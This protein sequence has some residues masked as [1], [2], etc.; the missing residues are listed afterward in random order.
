MVKNFEYKAKD[1]Y[2]ASLQGMMQAESEVAVAVALRSKGYFITQIKEKQINFLEMELSLFEKRITTAD[3]AIF[4]RQFAVMIEAGMP[5][6]SVLHVLIEQTE[7]KKLR[8]ATQVVLRDV[9]E[10]ETLARAMSYHQKIFPT[11]MVSMVEAG[12]LGGVLDEVMERVATHLEKEHKLREK[13]KGAMTYPKMVLAVAFVIVMVIVT[14]IFPTFTQLFQNANIELPVITKL[15]I[16][17][18]NVIRNH[19]IIIGICV[20]LLVLVVKRILILPTVRPVIDGAKLKLP[21][22]GDLIKKI[23]IA[24]FCRTLSTLVKGGVGLL[25]ALE[26]VKRVTDNHVI[27]NIVSR[28]ETSIKE[29]EGL[30]AQLATSQVFPAM[31]VRMT[32]IGEET[33][34]LDRMLEKVADFFESE[35]EDKVNNLSK[36]MEPLL[37]VILAV[38]V[39]IIVLAIML[40]MF[41]LS[42]TIH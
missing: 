37:I 15:L 14:F 20:L 27:I 35:V 8:A 21:I 32:A 29:G 25:S 34:E 19:Y 33:G 36:L 10:G 9:Q 18:S 6:L 38:I 7:N 41:E 42:S 39:G 3:L 11:I 26:V 24:H 23:A 17:I 13:I 12:E 22:F 28:A 40:P 2:G 4:A 1:E 31:V 30:A 5:L 16:N